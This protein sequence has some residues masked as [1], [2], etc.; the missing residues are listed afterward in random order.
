MKKD[1][2]LEKDSLGLI[3]VPEDA[4][5]GAQT[6]RSIQNF[7]IGDDLVPIELIYAIVLIKKAAS[8]A[9]YNLGLL[10]KSKRNLI[11][12]ISNEIL[13]GKYN[14]HFPLKI[15]QTGSG[16]QTNMNVNEVISN[17]A[18]IKNK[19]EVGSHFP[20]HPNDDINKSQSTNDTFPA[21]IQIS[22]VCEIHKKL[23][24]AIKL[25]KDEFDAKSNEW[26][27]IIK[28]GRTHFQDA[29][30]I[31]LGQEISGWSR[32]LDDAKSSILSSLEALYYLPIGGTAVGTGINCPVNF[33][34]EAIKII[35]KDTNYNFK[36]SENHYS[37][38]AS[39]HVLANI[40]CQ[41]KNLAGSL[42]KISN[43]IKILSSGPRAGIYEL[44]IPQNEPGS[45][46]MPGK[47]N[48]TQCESLS[49]ICTQIMGLEYAVSIANCSGTLQ[50]NEYKPL[51]SFNLLKSIKL[52]SEG[53]I[54]FK[55]KLV[56]G[57]K[58]N[59]KAIKINVESSLML[60][61]ALVP[62]IGYEKASEIAN[63][64]FKE[65]INLKE[66]TLKLGYL[67]EE[68]FNEIIKIDNMI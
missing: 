34:E 22:V 55:D 5:W 54:N 57:M 39:H 33:S 19:S 24:P 23:L 59:L 63:L 35:N 28:I 37:L 2:R 64:A 12:E 31:S 42:F 15:W 49:M 47:V 58:P 10:N 14:K 4:L 61:T 53:L 18:S 56:I 20:L 43:D 29:V 51:I 36:K 41:L 30:P 38:M 45:S 46:I 66:A 21:A 40:M 9:N 65:S 25:L 32:Q 8:I 60:V 67:N 52:M 16:T 68:Q 11:V 62:E 1:F 6:Q 17:V 50:M 48:P 44:L 13:N 27:D 3:K 7:S 26:A